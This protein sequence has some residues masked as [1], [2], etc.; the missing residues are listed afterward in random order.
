[1]III[2]IINVATVGYNPISYTSTDCNA[3]HTLWYDRFIPGRGSS[4][5][6]RICEPF[7]LALNACNF[8][9]KPLI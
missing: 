2:T 6:H 3:T 1:V 8:L 4:Y 5:N 7:P 9:G